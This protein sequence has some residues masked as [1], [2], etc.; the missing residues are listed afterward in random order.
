M[1]LSLYSKVFQNFHYTDIIPIIKEYGYDGIEFD[2]LPNMGAEMLKE[3]AKQ[4]EIDIV[5][6]HSEAHVALGSNI[7]SGNADKRFDGSNSIKEAV[8]F[9]E[10]CGCPVIQIKGVYCWPYSSPRKGFW[11]RAREE[12]KNLCKVA[13]AKN[14]KFALNIKNSIAYLFNS[15][16]AAIEMIEEVGSHALG[17]TFD[18]G[19]FNLM[20]FQATSIVGFVDILK[21][22]IIHVHVSDNDGITEQKLPPGRGNINWDVFVIALSDI[23]YKGYISVDLEGGF[24]QPDPH[25]ASYESIEYLKKI[26]KKHGI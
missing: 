19:V 10:R 1:K 5:S 24:N 4:K 3:Y 25:G 16:W 20:T 23:N 14:V 11:D 21:D 17:V 7:A 8:D 12:L 13:E 26:F 22:H 18:A 9:A 6:L 15:P 2:M